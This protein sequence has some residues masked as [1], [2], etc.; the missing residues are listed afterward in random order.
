MV[1]E[2]HRKKI[3]TY[4]FTWKASVKVH[5]KRNVIMPRDRM[6]TNIAGSDWWVQ[7]VAY[8]STNVRVTIEYLFG[9]ETKKQTDR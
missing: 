8:H 5:P 2:L 1:V 6:N 9:N 3:L 7:N 4:A